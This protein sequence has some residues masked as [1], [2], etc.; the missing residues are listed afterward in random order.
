MFYLIPGL[1][2][3]KRVFQKLLPLLHGPAQVLEWLKPIGDEP[4]PNYVQRMAAAIPEEQACFVVGV[5]FGGTVALE[6]C[7][8]RPRACA[9]L[10]SSI[11]DASR[12]PPLLRLIRATR[13]YKLVP[14][15][16][17]KLFPWAGRWYFGINGNIE[18]KVFKAI[19]RDM[20]SEYTRWAI[21]RLLHWDSTGLG[22]CVQI[23]GSRDRVFPPSPAPVDYL[24]PGGTHFMVLTHAQQISEILNDLLRKQCRAQEAVEEPRDARS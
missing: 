20:D 11:S 2:A 1:G 13:V 17:L 22:S 15:P 14:P 24:I 6:I 19:L 16:L 3:D 9:V 12:L 7:R 23:L 5:S 18:Y 10:V 4:L 21:E 8:I